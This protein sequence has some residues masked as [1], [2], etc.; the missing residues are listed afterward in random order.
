[1]FV[2]DKTRTFGDP[3]WEMI[4]F[5][6]ITRCGSETEILWI[7]RETIR[8][9]NTRTF[10]PTLYYLNIRYHFYFC[11]ILLFKNY[12]HFRQNVNRWMLSWNLESN[13][14]ETHLQARTTAGNTASLC[15]FIG[16]E[17]AFDF[18]RSWSRRDVLREELQT[19]G[20]AAAS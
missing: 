1:M 16:Y 8:Q 3:I 9:R 13:R 6:C 5:F 19:T 4:C 14:V 11:W 15:R 17:R 20:I 2:K 10:C 12:Q 18:G 7:W